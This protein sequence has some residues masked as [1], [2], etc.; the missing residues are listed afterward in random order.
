MC[1]SCD[2]NDVDTREGRQ[3]R[4]RRE[5][6]RARRNEH[7]HDIFRVKNELLIR[8]SLSSTGI[9]RR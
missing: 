4:G 6:G 2:N 5:R 9:A 7:A 3:R 8:R 1:G